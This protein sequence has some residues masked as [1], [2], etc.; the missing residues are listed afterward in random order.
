MVGVIEGAQT[1]ESVDVSNG[2]FEVP[3]P[4]TS[5]ALVIFTK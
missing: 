5:A 1:I 2:V 4:I 3:V